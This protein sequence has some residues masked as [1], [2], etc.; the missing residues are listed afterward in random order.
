M[1]KTIVQVAIVGLILL[2]LML[3]F[4]WESGEQVAVPDSLG[5]LQ[6]TEVI[7]GQE[8]QSHI[9][10]LHGKGVTPE[11]NFIARYAGEDGEAT[12][13]ISQYREKADASEAESKMTT[14][15]RN[16]HPVFGHYRE[17][18]MKGKSIRL[19]LGMGQAHF[20]F[21]HHDRVYWLSVDPTIAQSTIEDL[22][23]ALGA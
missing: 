18:T 17:I 20:F 1:S 21:A 5:S 7:T 6:R 11:A 4:F 16:G 23:Q 13:F 15:I 19:C 8:A 9:D 10:R 22:V 14:L 2:V 3:V 12:L